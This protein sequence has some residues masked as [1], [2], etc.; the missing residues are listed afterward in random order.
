MKIRALWVDDQYKD[1]LA[2]ISR[3]EQMGIDITPFEYAKDGIVEL[4][5]KLSLHYYDAVILDAKGLNE[6]SDKTLGLSGLRNLRD[7]LI[8]INN[9]YYLPFF[10]FTGQPDY[11]DSSIFKES[12]GEYYIK[13]RDNEALFADIKEKVKNKIEYSLRIKHKDIFEICSGKY[14]GSAASKTLLTILKKEYDLNAFDN[15]DVY[16]NSLRKIVEDLFKTCNRLGLLP[17]VFIEGDSVAIN[18]ACDFYTGKTKR[19]YQIVDSTFPDRRIVSNNLKSILI[20]CQP[21]SHRSYIDSFLSEN[22]K[23]YLLLS[24]T[25]QILNVLSWFKRYFDHHTDI[26]KNKLIYKQASE[27]L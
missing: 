27:S 17:D 8:E 16:F 20:M 1:Q 9:E 24:N 6:K 10:I 22:N 5:E 25:Y 12:F 15:T 26:E 4:N 19:G 18:E 13:V 11:Q 3:A 2:F 7:R 14:L 23:P 21:G